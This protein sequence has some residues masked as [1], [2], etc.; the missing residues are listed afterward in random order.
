LIAGGGTAGHVVPALALAD[1]LSARG[2][3]VHF[4]G[5]PGGMEAQLVPRSGYPFYPVRIR[6]F[7][8]RLGLTT[9]R[10]L[11]SLPLA[12]WDAARVLRRVDPACVVG[13]GAY[14]SGP[15]V[16][17]ASLLL[18]R[19]SAAVEMDAYLGWTNRILSRIVDRVFLSFPGAHAEGG[20]FVHTGRPLRPGLLAA[21]RDEGRQRF[22]LD[23]ETPA[24]LVFGGSLG[25]RPLNDAALG[26]YAS[27]R[28]PFAVLHV[29]GTR[30]EERVARAV[31]EGGNPN[32]Q[33]FGFLDDFPLVL[34]AADLA[35]AR[36]GGSVAELLARGL[37]SVLVPWPGATADHQSKN[38]RAIAAAG[39]ALHL[40][41]S[42]LSPERLAAE[43]ERLLVPEVRE[44]MRGAALSL[45]RPDAATRIADEIVEL[46]GPPGSTP[47]AGSGGS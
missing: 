35:V 12:G 11:L 34:A 45:A 3:E 44:Q 20:K 33:V 14:A 36:A 22:G 2:Y 5:G 21:T 47:S 32:Y 23:E 16:A 41:E 24:V 17:E 29:A 19:P 27:R 13:V 37:P 25:S 18:R 43:T 42:E 1:V 4:C 7:E 8:R 31:V 10:T 6:G 38:A 46:A 40:P 9:V 26:A 15:V 39:A 30:D 28:T